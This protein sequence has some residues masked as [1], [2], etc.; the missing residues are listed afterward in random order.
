[1]PS[2]NRTVA[3]VEDPQAKRR[4]EAEAEAA[5]T[6]RLSSLQAILLER[7]KSRDRQYGAPPGA[8]TRA[9]NTTAFTRPDLAVA[10][11]VNVRYGQFPPGYYPAP[12]LP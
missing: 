1:M 6:D 4:R 8:G 5:R 2:R 9:R 3:P 11:L 12:R 7:L 10:D